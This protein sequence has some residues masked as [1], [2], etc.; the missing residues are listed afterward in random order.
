M[1]VWQVLQNRIPT[2]CKRGI[3]SCEAQ[4]CIGGYGI[5]KTAQLFSRIWAKIT[6]WLEA[7]MVK[8]MVV[9]FWRRKH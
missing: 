8:F 1:F 6:S 4:F 3:L 5:E 9:D 2:K 7:Q